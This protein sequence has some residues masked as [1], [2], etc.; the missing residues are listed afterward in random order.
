MNQPIDSS[1]N[2][3]I[4]AEAVRLG[5]FRIGF[6]SA[7]SVLHDRYFRRWLA[8]GMHGEMGYLQRQASKRLNP[9]LVFAN[10]RSVLVLAM[11]YYT[12][13]GRANSALRGKISRYAWGDDYHVVVKNRL[14]MLL[15][16]ILGQISSA[17]GR[18]YVDTGPVMEK[19]WGAKTA[20]GWM[21]KHT[22]L[23]V[24]DAGSWF[25]IGVIL[26]D[27]QLECDRREKDF[28]GTC[29]RC[30][31]ACP[32]G[33]I[34]APYVLDARRCI[35][36][37][38]IELRGVIPRHLRSLMGNRIFGCD[39]CQEVCPW[40]RFAVET[41]E[42]EFIP[43]QDSFMPELLPLVRMTS[44]EFEDR[45]K[46]S[47]IRRARR[48]GFVRNVAV[49]LGNSHAIEAIPALERALEDDSGIVRLHAAWGLGEIATEQAR[50]ILERARS[51]ESDPAVI[52][53]IVLSLQ[54][55]TWKDGRHAIRNLQKKLC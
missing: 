48:E 38:T 11:N 50:R 43:K 47:P 36:Y 34:V 1:L 55:Q 12:A 24:R 35:S 8:D 41:A 49:A 7:S 19:A 45:F 18:C 22:N 52:E 40:N 33:A 28:C 32:T 31:K 4:R 16:Y 46:K 13:M 27:A 6:A 51:Y 2:S 25:F 9:G 3:R 10:T 5:F 29:S 39:D 17:H 26:L 14:E 37:L 23:I 20:L 42:P 54:N 44:R 15:D 21:G 53:E 30:I